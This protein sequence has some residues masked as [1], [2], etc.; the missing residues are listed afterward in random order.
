MANITAVTSDPW[1]ESERPTFQKFSL[2]INAKVSTLIA[3]Q[4][5]INSEVD[6]LLQGATS[7]ANQAKII[8]VMTSA[9]TGWTRDPSFTSGYILRVTDGSTVPS[10]ESPSAVGGV[11]GGSWTISGV[12]MSTV[13]SHTH[14]MTHTHTLAGHTHSSSSHTHTMGNHSHTLAAHTHTVAASS[15]V[16]LSGHSSLGDYYDSLLPL[17]IGADSFHTHILPS[18]SHGGVTGNPYDAFSSVTTNNTGAGT[19]TTGA[20]SSDVTGAS[21]ASETGSN[22]SHTHTVSHTPSWVPRCT[23]TIVCT[24]D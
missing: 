12:S 7:G 20:P 18:H 24:K 17:E 8:F 2:S 15:N 4:N 23:S 5:L 3:N 21:S 9:P 19:A 13:S 11:Q 1:F 16:T 6:S 14:S 22:S 10:G